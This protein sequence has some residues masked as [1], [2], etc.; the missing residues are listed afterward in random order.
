MKQASDSAGTHHSAVVL[1]AR[2]R[3]RSCSGDGMNDDERRQSK[4]GVVRCCES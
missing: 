2:L 1:I 4:R 3:S